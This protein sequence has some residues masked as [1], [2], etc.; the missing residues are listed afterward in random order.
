MYSRIL[1]LAGHGVVYGI[2][3]VASKVIALLLLPI[4]IRYLEP[5][6]YGKAE[7]VMTLVLFTS[8]L[9]KLGLQNAMMR[10]SYDAPEHERDDVAARVVQTTLALTLMSLVVFGGILLAFD[11]QVAQF[12]LGDPDV[13]DLVWY[14]VLGLWTSVLYATITATF[15]IQKRPGAF[16]RASL[17]N[18]IASAA[19]TLYFVT[20]LH[21]GVRGL[22]LGNFLG[23]LVVIPFAAWAQREWVL[24]RIDRALV[25][26][27]LLFALPTIPM[28]VAF[29]SLTLIDRT[30]LSRQAGLDELGVYGI[31]ARFAAVVLIVVTALQLSWQPFAYSIEDD[32]EARRSYAIVTTWFAAGMGWIVSG[33]ALLADPVVRTMTV[34]AY[35]DA[36]HLV[37]LLALAAGIYGAYFLVGIGTSRVKRTTWHILVASSAVAVSLVANMTLVR[38]YGATGAAIAAVLANTT[39]AVA[40]L[41][42]S[43]YVFRVDYELLRLARPIALTAI[44]LVACYLLPTGTGLESWG[45]RIAVALA[46]PLALAASGFATAPERARIARLMRRVATSRSG[47]SGTG[48][49]V[50]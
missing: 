41:I 48:T 3:S 43:Q 28:A 25:R 50:A 30:V 44:A 1:Q 15:R 21:L 34:P 4:I 27:M 40:M 36:A 19:L 32:D 26:P 37:P 35:Y 33:M 8:A 20:E 2:G 17:G 12:F 38:E 6:S 42:R 18:V 11:S 29:Q 14:A 23:F 9:V 49:G 16:L 10:F 39:L 7:V 47:G 13:T 31:A 22:L 24:P 45:S 46:W 5:S